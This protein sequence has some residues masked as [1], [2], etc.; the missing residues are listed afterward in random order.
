MKPFLVLLI[1]A[2]VVEVGGAVTMSSLL[3]K[4]PIDAPKK[5]RKLEQTVPKSKNKK[6]SVVTVRAKAKKS[7]R[8][9]QNTVKVGAKKVDRFL[10]NVLKGEAEPLPTLKDDIKE[11]AN[12]LKKIEAEKQR[13]IEEDRQRELAAQ[14]ERELERARSLKIQIDQEQKKK[15]NSKKSRQL[16]ERKRLMTRFKT[17]D[18]PDQIDKLKSIYKSYGI[19][20]K[21]LS[22]KDLKFLIK[23]TKKLLKMYYDPNNAMAGF[24]ERSLGDQ[25][26]QAGYPQG[27]PQQQQP[28]QQPGPQMYA[29]QP[30]GP[31]PRQ[32]QGPSPAMMMAKGSG[33][34]IY[35]NRAA[36]GDMSIKFPDSPPVVVTNQMPYYSN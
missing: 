4:K 8:K 33:D 3:G 9:N 25:G 6:A 34:S 24:G 28:Q 11:L 7:K 14:R 16:R 31:D 12:D 18:T 13:K 19:K 36:G 10:Q 21:D 2:G 5:S 15:K 17:L 23:N 30:Q 32:L 27:Y 1:V 35:A 29:G 26:L 20:I 22:N